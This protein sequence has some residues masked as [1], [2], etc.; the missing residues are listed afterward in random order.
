MIKQN[1]TCNDNQND[2]KWKIFWPGPVCGCKFFIN[3]SIHLSIYLSVYRS[4][5]LSIYRSIC[6]SLY[7]SFCLSIYLSISLSLSL[8]VCLSVCLSVYLPVYLPAWKRSTSARLPHFSTLT[9]AKTKQFYETSAVFELDNL[10]NEA[11]LR[12]FFNFW[13]WQH[14]KQSNSARLPWKMESKV[15][16]LTASYQCVLQFFHS[17]YLKYCACQEKLMPGHA[18]C[19]TCHANHLS[20]PTDLMLQNATPLRKS[21]P[22]PPNISHDHGLTAPATENASLQILFKCPTPAI[23]FGNATK[24]SRFAH[25]GQGAQSFAPATRNDI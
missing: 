24:P 22:W 16:A 8:S 4:S 23:V 17:T 14:Q 13:T 5:C 12:D 1:D 18:M 7:L 19:C 3:L 9:T 6:L 2:K 15:Q 10:Q 21:A 20:K 11:I 25:F